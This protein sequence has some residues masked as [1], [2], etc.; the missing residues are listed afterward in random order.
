MAH[1]SYISD[2]ALRREVKYVL[3]KAL[4]KNKSATKDF[5]KNVIDPFGS[6]FEAPNFTSHEEWKNSETARQAQK[7][8]QNHVGLFHQKILGEVIGWQD[9]G[10]GGVVDLLCEERK[11][12]AEVKNKFSTVTFGKLAE[13][14]HS[15]NGLISP[16]HSRFKEYTAYFVNV[17]PKKPIR[18]NEPFTPSDKETG[19]K[20]PT[21]EKIRIIDGASFYELT[22]GIENAL[23]QLHSALPLVIEDIYK[24][25]YKKGSFKIPNPEDFLKYFN[26]AYLNTEE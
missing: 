17:I 15:L 26:L 16:K 14:Y 1:L 9:L 11:I 20:C 2:K 12:I 5:N 8:I 25:E 6:L 19:K 10:T 13:Q 22:T 18:S 24:T 3:D 7:T 4:A 23:E 21:N